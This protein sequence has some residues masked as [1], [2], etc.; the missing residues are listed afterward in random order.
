LGVPLF[1][2][3][4]MQLAVV[5]AG[6]TAG[7]ADV[8]R[9]AMGSKRSVERMQALRQRLYDG[10]AAKSI[11]RPAADDIW[12]TMNCLAAFGFP[13]S[14]SISI[15]FLALA[16]SCLKRLS[17]AAFLAGLIN[18]QPMGFCSPQTLVHDARRHGIEVRG[19]D[20]NASACPG[21]R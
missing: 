7:E 14:H 4:L 3:Q 20:I 16:S 19:V 17:P 8:L 12:E 18:A 15:A 21:H 9:R 13:E 11:T 6:F 1:Q 10:M 2:E 5:A